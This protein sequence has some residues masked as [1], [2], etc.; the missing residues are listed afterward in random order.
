MGKFEIV[1]EA[2]LQAMHLFDEN[3]CCA[4]YWDDMCK[5][6]AIVMFMEYPKYGNIH[7]V[8]RDLHTKLSSRMGHPVSIC[9]NDPT[10][11]NILIHGGAMDSS[12]Y[13]SDECCKKNMIDC[14]KGFAFSDRKGY[15]DEYR[16]VFFAAERLAECLNKTPEYVL[17]M[18][19]WNKD[20][21]AQMIQLLM[22]FAD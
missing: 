6:N 1:L 4:V 8:M 20:P 14:Y 18:L 5:D 21:Q 12:V 10:D 7:A 11:E 22:D 16:S 13:Y 2:T 19:D 9:H 15:R 17:Q 3:M